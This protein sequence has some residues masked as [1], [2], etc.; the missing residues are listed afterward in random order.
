MPS[1]SLPLS[2]PSVLRFGVGS[3]PPASSDFNVFDTL[4]TTFVGQPFSF[5]VIGSSHYIHSETCGFYELCSCNSM[6]DDEFHV[7]TLDLDEE[8]TRE[9]AFSTDFGL[10][11]QTTIDVRPLHETSG[12]QPPDLYYEFA[13]RAYTAIR[14]DDDHY[15]TFHTYPEH[16]VVVQTRTRILLEESGLLER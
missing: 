13:E 11:C 14:I 16:D 12:E 7:C 10:E 1:D 4:T 9:L 15:D 6:E 2:S 8:T 5:D 3:S